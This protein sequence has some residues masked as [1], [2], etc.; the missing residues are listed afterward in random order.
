MGSVRCDMIR[1]EGLMRLSIA[2][3]KPDFAITKAGQIDLNMITG[4]GWVTE[5]IATDPKLPSLKV[6]PLLEL[7]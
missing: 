7:I 2:L 1:Q 6:Q 4:G 3:P 5:T